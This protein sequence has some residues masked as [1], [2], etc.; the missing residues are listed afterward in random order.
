MV[1][2]ENRRVALVQRGFIAFAR[3]IYFSKRPPMV[4]LGLADFFGS[5][6]W[7]LAF[8]LVGACGCFVL[9]LLKNWSLSSRPP[10]V[11]LLWGVR[12]GVSI[13]PTTANNFRG[14]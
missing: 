9:V 4:A 14:T 1:W 6:G 12:G 5:H 7:P 13:Y 3:A 11:F 2:L 10:A 8:F